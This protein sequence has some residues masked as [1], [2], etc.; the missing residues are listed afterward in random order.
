M[1]GT[2]GLDFHILSDFLFDTAGGVDP[3]S[4]AKNS[5]YDKNYL[6]SRNLIFQSSAYPLVLQEII[7]LEGKLKDWSECCYQKVWV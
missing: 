2:S 6:K 7:R 3:A 4:F 1:A 5:I